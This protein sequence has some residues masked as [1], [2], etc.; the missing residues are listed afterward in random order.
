MQHIESGVFGKGPFN[1]V[2]GS[3]RQATPFAGRATLARAWIDRVIAQPWRIPKTACPY[4]S[5]KTPKRDQDR[6]VV[7]GGAE[8]RLRETLG[9]GRG[10][11]CQTRLVATSV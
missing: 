8:P 10:R 3:E 2:W 9:L 4:K 1:T 7:R 6:A 11:V 5:Y